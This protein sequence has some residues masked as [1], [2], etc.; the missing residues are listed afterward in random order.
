MLVEVCVSSIE[1]VEVVDKSKANRI[2]LCSTMEVIGVTPS[3]GMYKQAKKITN[4]P[5]VVMIRPRAGFYNYSELEFDVMKNDLK[6]FYKEGARDFVFGISKETGEIDKKRCLEL[7]S[8]VPKDC[9]FTYHKAFDYVPDKESGIKTLIELGFDR[10]LTSGGLG[11]TENHLD[12]LE[13]LICNHS[14]EIEIIVGGGLHYSNIEKIHSRL[15]HQVYHLSAK[16][17]YGKNMKYVGTD[18]F[19]LNKFI[20]V[21]QRTDMDNSSK[22]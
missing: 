5:M 12:E 21:L 13:K 17:Y 15:N 3:I 16:K 2:E 4:K 19:K 11:S 10:V 14:N 8:T 20:N 9:S 18:L 7:M 1:D 22:H 6:A